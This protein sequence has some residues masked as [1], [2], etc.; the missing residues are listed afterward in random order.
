MV[1]SSGG[2]SSYSAT[3]VALET[4]VT[5]IND[6]PVVDLNG[7][8]SG[9]G[10][11][12]VWNEGKN[13]THVPVTLVPDATLTD[14][15]STK[16]SS[17]RLDLSGVIDGKDRLIVA[18]TAFSL[19]TDVSNTDVGAFFVSYDS[20]QKRFTIT[21]NTFSTGVI[22]REFTEFQSLL[23]GVQYLHVS[24][25]PK[26][27]IR[28]IEVRVVDSGVNNFA[29][30]GQQTSAAAL[31]NLTVNPGNDQPTI[32]GLTAVTFSENAV[33]SAAAIIDGDV[34]VTEPDSADL[35]GGT[36]TVSGLDASDTV[37][38]PQSAV[39]ASGNVRGSAGDLQ[40]HD[41]N[42]WVTVGTHT[43]GSGVDLVV[44]WNASATPAI[45]ERVIEN[46]TFAHSAHA[47]VTFRTLSVTL[48]DGDAG[49]I[50]QTAT[51]DVTITRD[52]D[53]PSL[54]A[55]SRSLPSMR[56]RACGGGASAWPN[57]NW[58]LWSTEGW[59][60]G[61]IVIRLITH[62]DEG[63]IACGRRLAQSMARLPAVPG[64]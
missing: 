57:G 55:T 49:G 13:V 24:D 38:V 25:D 59:S 42:A 44:T 19:D 43:G 15:D 21:P 40:Y 58:E 48:N 60:E 7:G 52:N 51:V 50:L 31:L 3:T 4:S 6:A 12:G 26:A 11:V 10:T 41:G 5:A 47:P 1:S 35:D 56:R 18:G 36:L 16:A 61:G 30:S 33:N 9:T 32:T 37:S 34:T 17:L 8:L 29:L 64:S 22:L 27:G 53:A 14:V 20:R 28:A 62:T 39:A 46:L 2:T 54:S 45:A 63:W 23:R